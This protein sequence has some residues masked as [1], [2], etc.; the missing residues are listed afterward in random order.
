MT[1]CRVSLDAAVSL[2][3][4]LARWGLGLLF[5]Y[6]GFKKALDPV[7]FLK[8]VR[9]Y[10]MVQ[11]ALMLNLIA[12]TLPWFEVFCGLLLLGGIAVRGTAV[13]SLL[14]LLPFTVIVLR[15]ALAI[16]AAQ[17]LAF[18]AVRFDCGC[19]AGEVAICFKLAE[20]ILLILLSALLLIWRNDHC[21][22]KYQW[23]R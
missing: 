23:F 19:G 3:G 5:V 22:L 11:S 14:M 1:V 21:T 9:Q 20:N 18:C 17:Q 8:L 6:M 10:D 2:L 16:Q 13:V 15:R 4:T 12:S 7:D